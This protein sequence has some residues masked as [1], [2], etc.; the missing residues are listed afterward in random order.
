MD[1]DVEPELELEVEPETKVV[2]QPEPCLAPTLTPEAEQD[3]RVEAYCE[4]PEKQ[5]RTESLHSCTAE[6]TQQNASRGTMT[7]ISN[8]LN[9][10]CKEVS[11]GKEVSSGG[12]V[13]VGSMAGNGCQGGPLGQ[14]PLQLSVETF[15]QENELLELERP[16]KADLEEEECGCQRS[17]HVQTSKHL[18]WADKFIQAS[19]HSLKQE[20]SRKTDKKNTDKNNSHLK[21]ESVPKNTLCSKEQLQNPSIQPDLPDTVSNQPQSAPPPNPTFQ[22]SIG[23]EDLINFASSLAVASSSK[24]DLPSL[25]HMIKAPP[26]KAMEPSTE[27]KVEN[28]SKPAEDKPEQDKLS[29]LPK[30]SPEKPLEAEE[31]H[32]AQKLEHKNFFNDRKPRIQKTTIQGQLK[33][34]QPPAV[35]PL[36]QRNEKK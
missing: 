30:K 28:A 25:E 24:M 23:L 35:P 27:P 36:Q 7:L 15:Q 11:I 33:L 29:E 6:L 1:M 18:F 12:W 9:S 22:P 32:R 17:I 16:Q 20:I 14:V 4:D 5:D 3:S 19:E 26:Q 31:P 34:L 8:S 21:Q 13:R 10:T 2:P